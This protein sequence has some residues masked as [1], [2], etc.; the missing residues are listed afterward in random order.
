VKIFRNFLQDSLA[1]VI[2]RRQAFK[3]FKNVENI[4]LN[5]IESYWPNSQNDREMNIK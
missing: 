5:L 4:A 1:I 2:F 3:T